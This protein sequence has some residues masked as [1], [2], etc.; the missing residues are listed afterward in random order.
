MIQ[1]V[2]GRL[3]RLVGV[4][5]GVL[6][7]SFALRPVAGGDPVEALLFGQPSSPETVANLRASFGLDQPL[8]VQYLA[9]LNGVVRGDLGISFNTRRPVAEEIGDRFWNTL[10]LASTSMC[11]GLLL[12]VGA[13]VAAALKR[14]SALDGI[15]LLL[16]TAG[17]A[18]PSFWLGILLIEWF[19]VRLRWLP[20]AGAGSPA[21]LVLPVLT[22]AP[23]E[24]A[25]LARVARASL[26][27][28][29]GQ[30]YVRTARAK[31]LAE[32]T[33][34]LRHALRS[35]LIPTLTL[36]SLQFGALLGGALV[37]E[38]IFA[39]PGLGQLAARAVSQ[40]D[41]PVIQ[42]IAVLLATTYVLANAAV[43]VLCAVL[44]PRMREGVR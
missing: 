39:W 19:A 37:V 2:L 8:H 40:R 6:T 36:A 18:V 34:V 29:L 31:G 26:L 22:L 17:L 35:A 4:C 32:S 28:V 23:V 21:H 20:V 15:V 38:N 12:G 11:L 1:R 25:A 42:G 33:V 16:S 30:D 14:G 5:F 10:L 24:A 41:Y 27:D 43:D 44:D 3:V 9:Y 7:L 13:G